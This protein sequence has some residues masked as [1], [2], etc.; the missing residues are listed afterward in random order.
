[1]TSYLI[2]SSPLYD[3]GLLV[4]HSLAF[5]ASLS[6]GLSVVYKLIACVVVIISALFYWRQSQAF[7]AY[8]ISYETINGW[9]WA[10]TTNH[11][12]PMTILPTTVLTAQVIVLHFRL[13]TGKKRSLV[14]VHDALGVQDY[15]RLLV[16]LKISKLSY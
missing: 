1:V 8:T 16:N 5:I 12:Q 4:I 13:S 15:R 9:Q 7:Q 2:K 3:I 11:Y 10:K 14:I 6:H